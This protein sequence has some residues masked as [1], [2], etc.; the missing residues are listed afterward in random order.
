V[1]QYKKGKDSLY[2][3]GKSWELAGTLNSVDF[4]VWRINC[5]CLIVNLGKRRYDRK[6]SGYGGQ[7]KPIFRKKVCWVLQMGA[8]VWESE[9]PCC[10]KF[11][12]VF[13]IVPTQYCWCLFDIDLI[14]NGYFKSFSIIATHGIFATIIRCVKWSMRT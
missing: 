2:A 11:K 3:Q 8:I 12:N 9:L 4:T 13:N 14:L 6:Q 10:L 7:T 5:I 1:T